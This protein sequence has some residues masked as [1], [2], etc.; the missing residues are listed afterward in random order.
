MN[1]RNGI[2]KTAHLITVRLVRELAV[3][4]RRHHD[5]GFT[6]TPANLLSVPI[7]VFACMLTC[8]VGYYADRMGNRGYFNLVCLALGMAGYIILIASRNAALSY[9]AIYL[10][11]A[12]IYPTLANST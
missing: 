3:L 12:G 7:Y 11:A 10:A 2:F 4:Q 9:V 6:A 5:L 1:L 8:T